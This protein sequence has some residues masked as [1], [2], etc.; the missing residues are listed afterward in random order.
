MPVHSRVKKASVVCIWSGPKNVGSEIGEQRISKAL[1]TCHRFCGAPDPFLLADSKISV[2]R[3]CQVVARS[4]GLAR[5][6]WRGLAECGRY[7]RYQRFHEIGVVGWVDVG[8][9]TVRLQLV[10]HYRPTEAIGVRFSP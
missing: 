8:V 3:A 9:Q 1:G 2:R 7:R 10:R 4:T 5:R 6:A